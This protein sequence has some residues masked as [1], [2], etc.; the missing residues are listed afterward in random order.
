MG[1]AKAARSSSRCSMIARTLA[2]SSS[3]YSYTA[4]L[5]KPTMRF[6]DSPSSRRS[7]RPG[8]VSGTLR[9]VARQRQLAGSAD[10]E[11]HVDGELARALQVEH[12][13]VLQIEVRVYLGL[14]PDIF[15]AHPSDAAL[16]ARSL[17][18][19]HSVHQ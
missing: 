17:A 8:A 6:S 9:S 4:T 13:D 7:G 15:A 18:D 14:V 16:E 10:P 5:R 11:R 3:W 1:P 19:E 12:D 2:R